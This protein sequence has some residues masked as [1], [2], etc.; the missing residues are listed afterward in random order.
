M[1]FKDDMAFDQT[2]CVQ[3]H[4]IVFK[5]TNSKHGVFSNDFL[6]FRHAVVSSTKVHMPTFLGR[7]INHSGKY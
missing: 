3:F 2:T 1:T 5:S 6:N 7:R 4:V